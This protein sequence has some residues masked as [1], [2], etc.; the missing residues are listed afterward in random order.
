MNL[1]AEIK[2]NCLNACYIKEHS[3]LQKLNGVCQFFQL[4]FSESLTNIYIY[5]CDIIL[6]LLALNSNF[7][8]FA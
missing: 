3:Q 7:L 8:I 5:I 2:I 4:A 6:P 1:E